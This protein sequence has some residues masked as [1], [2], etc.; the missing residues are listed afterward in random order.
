MTK[1]TYTAPQTKLLEVF[2][3]MDFLVESP[4]GTIPA[5]EEEPGFGQD[6]W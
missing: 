1:H 6:I 3:A 2:N 4:G 5:L